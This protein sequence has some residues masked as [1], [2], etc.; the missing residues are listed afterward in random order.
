MKQQRPAQHDVEAAETGGREV[1]D[2][3]GEVLD[4]RSAHRVSDPEVARHLRIHLRADPGADVGQP[5]EV[6]VARHVDRDHAQGAALLRLEGEKPVR[7]PDVEDALPAQ[8]RRQP[9]VVDD[10]TM[11]EDPA[12]DEPA[13]ELDGVVP[14]LER[15]V[16]LSRGQRRRRPERRAHHALLS[17][18]AA[19]AC[20]ELFASG[21]AVEPMAGERSSTVGVVTVNYNGRRYLEALLP[22]LL[23]SDFPADR[24][25][26]LVVD[27]G[28][29]DDSVAW[30]RREFP[31]VRIVETGRNRGFAG[32]C[33][34][35]I[36][37]SDATYVALTNNDAVVDRAWLRT[38]VE[39][40]ETDAR[41]GMVGSKVLFLTR[42]LDLRLTGTTFVPT[43]FGVPDGRRLSV[44]LLDARIAGC[45]Y[46]KV[47]YGSGCYPEER[48][49]ERRFRWLAEAASIAVPI[50]D[51]GAPATLL[52]TL[53]GAPW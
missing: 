27:N 2:A 51:P 6:S 22:S 7:R 1:V 28:S 21:T 38:L 37:A 30:I 49:G 12:R 25:E 3:A 10:G 36:R 33:N 24:F 44:R 17:H 40:A 11:V 34:A 46:D 15:R 43:D 26:V 20:Q 14:P 32:G 47:L 23:A 9:P 19:A 4:P 35:G 31:S 13:A 45:R 53:G 16:V 18:G 5:V 42:F 8:A 39:A 41:I 50:D 52:L 48:I 29:T